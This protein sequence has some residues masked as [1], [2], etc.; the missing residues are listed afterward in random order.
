[1]PT[2][3]DPCGAPAPPAASPALLSERAKL[4]PPF[5]EE[6][7]RTVY[8]SPAKADDDIARSTHNAAIRKNDLELRFLTDI[9]LSCYCN[10]KFTVV[11]APLF[12]VTGE[13]VSLVNP[14]LLA[15]TL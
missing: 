3:L 13:I 2:A 7:L 4:L 9:A 11:V 15:V 10:V 14:V 12:T 6:S 5:A 8:R 1:M